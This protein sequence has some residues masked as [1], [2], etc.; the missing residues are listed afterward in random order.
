MYVVYM[1]MNVIVEFMNKKY[2]KIK[3]I[4]FKLRKLQHLHICEE[5]SLGFWIKTER[6]IL[7]IYSFTNIFDYDSYTKLYTST[8]STIDSNKL[9][10]SVY[11]ELKFIYNAE[12]R[13]RI[14][15]VR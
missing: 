4:I 14:K 9:L 13:K 6:T 7:N 8:F 2:K 5:I 10:D 3:K 12:K 11:Q 15:N 1:K